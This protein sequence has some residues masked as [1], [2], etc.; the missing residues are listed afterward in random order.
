MTTHRV[1]VV[2]A[3]GSVRDAARRVLEDLGNEV[4]A[5][6]TATAAYALLKD[7]PVLAV[8]LDVNLPGLPGTAAY[9]VLVSRWPN[10]KTSIGLITGDAEYPMSRSGW[11]SIG[12]PW[13]G[14]RSTST[15][16]TPPWRPWGAD[17]GEMRSTAD[18]RCDRSDLTVGRPA[19]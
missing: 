15:S 9:H 17:A 7:E 8:L 16:W 10:L 18:G 6:A 5:T 2:D 11:P 14:S 4:L 19:T 3:Q 13:C 12:A 1:L